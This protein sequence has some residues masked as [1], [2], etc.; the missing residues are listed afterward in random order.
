MTMGSKPKRSSQKPRANPAMPPPEI[1]ILFVFILET[2]IISVFTEM[3]EIIYDPKADTSRPRRSLLRR[4]P[5]DTAAVVTP[6]AG[7]G[8]GLV[9]EA[10]AEFLRANLCRSVAVADR[11][12]P[13]RRH[14]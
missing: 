8:G 2:T 5:G 10:V 11:A 3:Q 6:R 9:R 13:A 1:M 14:R 12:A 7:A 4:S